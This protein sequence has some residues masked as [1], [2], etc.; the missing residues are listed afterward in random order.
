MPKKVIW[1]LYHVM[2]SGFHCFRCLKEEG[3]IVDGVAYDDATID[4]YL[5]GTL[6][7]GIFGNGLN[8]YHASK[9]AC[10]NGHIQD[11]GTRFVARESSNFINVD[12]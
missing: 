1:L 10:D 8:C 6:T 11:D 12:I 2:I 4:G 7:S 3:L 5:L 9:S